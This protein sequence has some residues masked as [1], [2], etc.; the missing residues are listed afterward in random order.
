MILGEHCDRHVEQAGPR[1]ASGHRRRALS[2]VRQMRNDTA[3]RWPLLCRPVRRR[4]AHR[5]RTHCG[6]R[7]SRRTGSAH[8]HSPG[9]AGRPGAPARQPYT[10]GLKRMPPTTSEVAP[11]HPLAPATPVPTLEQLQSQDD[12]PPLT[13]GHTPDQMPAVIWPRGDDPG[14]I[15][16]GCVQIR[17]FRLTEGLRAGLAERPHRGPPTPRHDHPRSA[18]NRRQDHDVRTARPGQCSTGRTIS[19]ELTEIPPCGRLW[20]TARARAV[21]GGQS[22]PLWRCPRRLGPSRSHTCP[23][24]AS[25]RSL[26][27]TS[28]EPSAGFAP[29]DPSSRT[30]TRSTPP[31]CSPPHRR[32]RPACVS[33]RWSAPQRWRSRP[34]PRSGRPAGPPLPVAVRTAAVSVDRIPPEQKRNSAARWVPQIWP[35]TSSTSRIACT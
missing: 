15:E 18:P 35:A 22:G 32:R 6:S 27:P 4:A 13:L 31:R 9:I 1:G 33:P 14:H 21:R 26:R 34:R 5:S 11:C 7:L 19:T 2:G 23:P 10:L 3:Y 24:S 25:T 29:P 17:L 28:P 30:R 12:G 8:P 16:V 20:A